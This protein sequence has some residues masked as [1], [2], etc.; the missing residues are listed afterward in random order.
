M[1]TGLKLDVL[2]NEGCVCLLHHRALVALVAK[3]NA[4][5][6]VALSLSESMS[7]SRSSST[8]TADCVWSAFCAMT[9]SLDS[10][11]RAF[12]AASAAPHETCEW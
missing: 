9:R 1:P 5:D 12:A 3:Y 6:G 7:S 8:T 11:L 10:F 4:P 2:V